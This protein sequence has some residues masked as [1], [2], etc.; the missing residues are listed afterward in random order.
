[1]I[2]LTGGTGF[3]GSH[4]ADA[5][6]AAGR[7]V[8]VAVR[9]NSNLQWLT[10]KPLTTLVTDLSDPLACAEFLRGTTGLVHCAG[11]ISGPDEAW[12]QAG[13]VQPTICLARAAAKVWS[14]A[15]P[16]TFV[17]ISSLAA[18]G[19]GSLAHPAVEDNPCRP[20][21]AYGR[22]KRDAEKVLL[23]ASGE[24]RRVIL[25]P[26]SL[27]GPRDREFLPLLRAATRGWTA[28]LG[29]K[30]SGLSLVDGRDAAAAVLAVLDTPTASGPYFISDPQ[31]GYDWEQIRTALAAA[32]GR[33]VRQVTIPLG[34][35]RLA[36]GVTALV[37]AGPSL[38][39]NRDRL[40]DLDTV[41][42]VCDGGRLVD[43]MRP[44]NVVFVHGDPE[45]V[46]WMSQNCGGDFARFTPT[47]GETLE[48]ES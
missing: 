9:A 27:Y 19:P 25:R 42:W 39:L 15:E 44:K 22:S 41:G 30:L 16:A 10:G 7:Q 26:P 33:K 38:L 23:S 34:A 18:H 11:V 46:D 48:L 1:M 35:V 43:E 24:F 37:G 17:L 6:L 2:A 4:I 5:L 12:Y 29:S 13:N 32:A 45:A 47:L 31:V 36:A 40:R 28:R 20:L 3:L 21:S 14:S 8:R